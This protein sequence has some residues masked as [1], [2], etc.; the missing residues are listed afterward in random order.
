MCGD[1][2]EFLARTTKIAPQTVRHAH[3]DAIASENRAPKRNR[4]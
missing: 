2:S 4:I 3:L 1:S